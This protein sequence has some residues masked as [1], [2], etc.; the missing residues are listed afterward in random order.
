MRLLITGAAGQL[1]K[2]LILQCQSIHHIV[3]GVTHAQLDICCKQ[4]VEKALEQFRPDVVINCASYNQVDKCED[5]D[6]YQIAYQVNVKGV[7]NLAQA[8]QKQGAS[9]VQL[10]T[11]YVFDGSKKTPLN[12]NDKTNPLNRYGYTKLMGEQTARKYCE[13]TYVVRTAWLYGDGSNFVKTML[14]LSVDK[15]ELFVV[16]DQYG[17][18]TS[19][20]DLSKAILT[21]IKTNSFG[22]YH[23]T[24][25]GVCT[26]FDFA[27]RIFKLKR[28]K[29]RVRPITSEEYASKAIRPKYSV[30]QNK[31][32]AELGINMFRD[33][34]VALEEYLERI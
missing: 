18:P 28:C 29:T 19:T 24:N 10:S 11:D 33:W 26:W 17:T 9:F 1:G 6:G 5:D 14:R 25:E 15:D 21:L 4:Q 13:K 2:E 22:I 8:A 16:N 31:N 34:Q 20:V 27:N 7:E 30:L 32:L 23:A 3:L 12:E